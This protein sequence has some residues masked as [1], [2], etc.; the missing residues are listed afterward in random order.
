MLVLRIYIR[1]HEKVK[2]KKKKLEP[3]ELIWALGA[4]IYMVE[5]TCECVSNFDD[6][7][8]VFICSRLNF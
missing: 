7:I 2:R 1:S 4:K 6:H 5:I 3:Q 8:Y